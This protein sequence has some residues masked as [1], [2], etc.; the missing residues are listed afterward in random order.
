MASHSTF[1]P[2]SLFASSLTALL[3]LACHAAA[4]DAT[5]TADPANP[6]GI[7]RLPEVIVTAEKEPASVQSVP[8]A[9]TT[10]TATTIR[11]ADIRVVKQAAV[12]APNVLISEFTAQKLSNPY[13]RGVG[14]SPTNPGVTTYIDGV[15]QLNAN[16]SNIQLV[17]VD[18]VEFV[19][20]PQGAL[21]GRNTL[22]G[23]I[24]IASRAP[25]I[26]EWTGGLETSYGSYNFCD[27]RASVS[28]PVIDDKVGL[29]LAGGYT[30]RSGYTKNAYTGKR[31][32]GRED[33]FGKFQLQLKA[34]E[35]YNARLIF[36]AERDHDGDYALGDLNEVRL[37]PRSVS[38]NYTGYT[39]RDI[40]APTLLQTLTLDTMEISSITG[41][42]WWR[43]TDSTDLDY[44]SAPLATRANQEKQYQLTQELRF[45]SRKDAPLELCENLKLAWQAG[46]FA[47]YQHYTQNAANDVNTDYSLGM[48]SIP[49][50]VHDQTDAILKNWGTGIYGQTKLTAWERFDFLAGLRYDY[51]N[52]DADLNPLTTTTSTAMPTL[53]LTSGS[54]S[55]LTR[56]Y[57]AVSPKFGLAWHATPDKMLY[58]TVT[59]GFKAGGFNSIAPAG[60]ESYGEEKSWCYEVGAKTEWLEGRLRANAAL[61]YIDWTDMQLNE[62]VLTVPGRY[63]IGNIGSANSK[64]VELELN[65][66]PVKGCDFFGS[67]GYTDAR[68]GSNSSSEGNDVS[69]HR[70]P[71]TPE[72][73]ACLGTQLSCDVGANWTLYTRLQVKFYGRFQYDA[74]NQASQ[75]G[76]RLADV[77]VGV[78]Q[79]NWFAECW[80]ENALNSHYVP[81][82][83][84][85]SKT[86]ASSGYIGENGAP[87][88]VGIRAGV[89]F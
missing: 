14:S 74:S 25:S 40:Y 84:E 56:N 34:T 86:Y 68:F 41:A 37:N 44:T 61:F 70:L 33:S 17:D 75:G 82:A 54:S 43:T 3:A 35:N 69:G 39:H 79:R 62:P 30:S 24:N 88:T 26:K 23:L 46:V 28:G 18:Q 76:Y 47:F 12:Y 55:D 59:R 48:Y 58:A 77:R 42:V 83:F 6:A 9:V 45:A 27:I 64:G 67:A 63:Y 20:D 78:R 22:G 4:A 73:T 66:R 52:A 19:R 57:Y 85:Y 51:E 87:M 31:L 5:A 71:Y 53:S 36:L 15:P 38:H 80:I 50:Q 2:A 49:I 1:Q 60:S 72:Y 29:S 10:V 81:I 8:A 65:Y 11:D 89:N 21:Y 7:T 16:S 32:D 13:F